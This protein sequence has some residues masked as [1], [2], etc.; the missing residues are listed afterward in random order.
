MKTII[1]SELKRNIFKKKTNLKKYRIAVIAVFL[2]VFAVFAVFTGIS[3]FNW[4]RSEKIAQNSDRYNISNYSSAEL[5]NNLQRTGNFDFSNTHLLDWGIVQKASRAKNLP[6]IGEISIPKL[7]VHLPI[8]L[9]TDD[10]TIATG[11]GTMKPSQ[12][13]GKGNFAL[14]SHNLIQTAPK[15]LFSPLTHAKTGM[16]VYLTD[17]SQIYT[18]IITN[19]E[20]VSV[21]R[22]D[23]ID[24]QPEKNE[25]TLVLCSDEA[26][27]A[28]E[29]V[30]GTFEK[31]ETYDS[32]PIYLRESF[33]ERYN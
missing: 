19:I 28:R 9:G 16:K 4:V 11:A 12:V 6:V 29:I 33:N 20:V 3:A 22:I 13:M 17:K 23:V 32:A 27:D 24:D 15:L 1:W 2:L 14:A 10:N 8:F 31:S 5:R 18:Y 25:L 7:K 30:H 26:G 21:E